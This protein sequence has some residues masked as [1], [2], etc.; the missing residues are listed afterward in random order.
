MLPLT[1][2]SL[3]AGLAVA[4]GAYW[5]WPKGPSGAEVAGALYAKP[6][7][8][9][10]AQL[11][12]FHLGHSLVG[13]DMPAM[14]AD[15]A[16]HE[17]DS[18]L[19]WGTSMQQHL[20]DPA[21][22][23]GYQATVPARAALQSGEY[24]ALVL[25]EMVEI[26]DA[27]RYHNS[28]DALATWAGMALA[29]NPNTRVYLYETW[30]HTDDPKGWLERID[31]DYESFWKAQILYPALAEGHDI[32]VIPAGQ[33]MAAVARMVEAREGL[34]GLPDRYALFAITPEGEQ[35]TIH[36]SDLGNYVVA[37]THAAVLYHVTPFE[38]RSRLQ[39][40]D[41]THLDI[42]PSVANEIQKTVWDVVTR[43]P[44]TG[45]HP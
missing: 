13:A 4:G 3:I 37:L 39:L 40:A 6:L 35:D 30:H 19:G 2:R 43:F 34:P 8:A 18:Q 9:P 23:N 31:A 44:E 21:G 10:K 17:Y 7:S 16:A 38:S 45:V 12:V 25:T 20:G 29:A 28:A 5:L 33:A 27:I 1:R 22:I 11:K 26:A 32:Y 14:L 24:D 36:L 41:G 15:L 42:L